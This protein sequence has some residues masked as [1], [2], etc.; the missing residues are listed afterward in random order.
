LDLLLLSE[1]AF[2]Y[3]R[4]WSL[5]VC[6]QFN[7]WCGMCT[8]LCSFV[9]RLSCIIQNNNSS[10]SYVYVLQYYY[11]MMLLYV[12]IIL[13]TYTKTYTF[14]RWNNNICIYSN[15]YLFM[16]I[17]YYPPCNVFIYLYSNRIIVGINKILCNSV[18]L[19]VLTKI[20]FYFLQ[21]FYNFIYNILRV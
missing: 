19:N 6:Q 14:K 7:V 2:I 3:Y 11:I 21:N 12:V 15:K 13:H 18:N 4:F 20:L 10:M 5:E 9:L 17:L 1:V 8:K 16:F